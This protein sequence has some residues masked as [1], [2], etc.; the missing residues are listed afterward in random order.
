MNFN[1]IK[2]IAISSAIAFSLTGCF[3]S[4]DGMVAGPSSAASTSSAAATVGGLVATGAPVP[5]GVVTIFNAS[6]GQVATVPSGALGE[7]SLS[8]DDAIRLANPF[9]WLVKGE[10]PGVAPVYSIAFE[11]DI[12]KSGSAVNLNPATSALL[13]MSGMDLSDGAFNANDL[14]LARGL[15]K[16][17]L[18]KTGEQLSAQ[19]ASVIGR[20]PGGV[21]S[22]NVFLDLLNQP[23]WG[24]STGLDAVLDAVGI[25]LESGGKVVLSVPAIGVSA[26][27]SAD[28]TAGEYTAQKK[29]FD[30]AVTSRG[31]ALARPPTLLA[32]D[33]QASWGGSAD[34]WAG[35]TGAGSIVAT[36]DYGRGAVIEF[37]LKD[38]PASGWWNVAALVNPASGKYSLTL[39]E[40]SGPLSAGRVYSFGF[41]G[42][43][44][45]ANFEAVLKNATG[46]K[47]NG[48]ACVISFGKVAANEPGRLNTQ[49]Y[50]S[51]FGKFFSDA[52]KTEALVKDGNLA[53]ASATHAASTLTSTAAGGAGQAASG[54]V[55]TSG[56]STSALT[57]TATLATTTGT[58][59]TTVSYSVTV[60]GAGAWSNGFNG[61][62]KVKNTSNSTI[63]NWGIVLTVP[64]GAFS[65]AP[66]V[67]NGVASYAGGKLMIKPAAWAK[68]SLD[69]GESWTSGMNGGSAQ[70]WLNVASTQ[71]LV[72][73]IAD[74]TL[75]ELHN[76]QSA[77]ATASATTAPAAPIVASNTTPSTV[78]TSTNASSGSVSTTLLG[79]KWA[80]IAATPD[81]VVDKAD[82]PCNSVRWGKPTTVSVAC[83][84][85]ME[86]HQFGGVKHSG[87]EDQIELIASGLPDAGKPKL[88]A[89]GYVV[90]WGVYGRKFAA[91]NVPAAAYSKLLHSF[92]R[93]MPD[94]SLTIPDEWATL[95]KDDTGK[96]LGLSGDP[97]SANWENQERGIM[98]RLTMLKAR[99][100]HLKTAYSVGGWTLSGQFSSVAADP[101]KRAQFIKSSIAFANRFGF[102]GIDIDWEYPVVGGNLDAN[103]P[104]VDYVEANPGKPEDAGNFVL[105]LK[106]LHA[107]IAS[108]P[109][110]KRDRT[111]SGKIEVSIAVGLGPKT[112]D[113]LNYKE[114]IDYVDTVNLMAYDFNGAWSSTVSHNAPLYD[115]HGKS[116]AFDQS[117]WNNHDA[118][119]NILWNLKNQ[120][121]A[122]TFA[123]LGKNRFHKNTSGNTTQDSREALLTDI[124][125][126]KYR[127]KLVL[128][129]PFYGRAWSSSASRP[130]STDFTPFFTGSPASIGSMEAGVFDSKD[131][132]YARDGQGENSTA[133]GRQPKTKLSASASDIVWDKYSC[134]NFLFTQGHI[135]SFDDEDAIYH[136]AKYVKEKGLGGVMV[137]E[138]DGDTTDGK[139]SKS[140][141]KGMRGHANSGLGATPK[142]CV[143]QGRN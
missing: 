95:Q 111:K 71:D 139:L 72:T 113:A 128:G 94:G 106:E 4:D 21:V 63:S 18:I 100:P 93:V 141:V 47:I 96:L 83:L 125:L 62:I 9:P 70:D 126:E 53:A 43:G 5:S 85:L 22:S 82:F 120:T 8:V 137:W 108:N 54:S 61:S 73:Y 97:F 56:G 91:E 136:K 11:S 29:V 20:L 1:F 69:P 51:S 34:L 114:F 116:A 65:G 58:G 117:E 60:S 23:F 39:P 40:W 64:S 25:K 17:R 33:A 80:N 135:V 37:T 118:I 68:Q 48:E 131:V 38:F 24:T 46:C 57:P 12:G 26:T 87:S 81:A 75:T 55:T 130:S 44:S 42:V 119:L 66:A 110:A 79:D 99:F 41:N 90:E 13:A 134:A 2:S 78:K 6:G 109:D 103:M 138:V 142:E 132:L 50:F 31:D 32:F 92:V 98:K 52:A 105:L 3:E 77:K 101:V 127:A 123:D 36:R 49:K 107:A 129:V 121:G 76:V 19:V 115:N 88:E 15:T 104:G 140:F 35:F 84:A 124:T 14:A 59:T 102:D 67:W 122:Q 86:K 30:D 143:G 112:I 74:A 7:W 89:F 10:A 45:R 28:M 27:F 133:N 16:E